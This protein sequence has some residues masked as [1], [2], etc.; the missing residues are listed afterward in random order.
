[1]SRAVRITN[2]LPQ[3]REKVE[4][5]AA[6]AI[7]QAL[8]LG[9]VGA[10]SLTPQH[11]SN[12]I[13]S[14]FTTINKIGTRIVGTTGFTAEYALAVHEAEGKLKGQPRPK[15]SGRPQGNYWDPRGE[16][17]FLEQGFANEKPRIDA[18]IKRALKG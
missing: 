16:P 11:T 5:R 1:M 9:G 4:Q 12:L 8:T 14:R 3:F 2:R 18:V 13:N 6:V 15:D 7:M 17:K 10:A